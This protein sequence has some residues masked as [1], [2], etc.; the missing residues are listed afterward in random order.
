MGNLRRTWRRQ[1]RGL[2]R[3][4]QT[5]SWPN[6]I[7]LCRSSKK[8]PQEF[9]FAVARRGNEQANVRF[10][11]GALELYTAVRIIVHAS[12]CIVAYGAKHKAWQATVIHAII[13][14]NPCCWGIYLCI[15]S[16]R[17]P[18]GVVNSRR[19][20]QRSRRPSAFTRTHAHSKMSALSACF[21]N[22]NRVSV[23]VPH[24]RL[25]E[26]LSLGFEE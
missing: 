13:S 16:D 24:A 15:V 21:S 10:Q 8:G 26:V 6:S 2:Q 9:H 19:H 14:K 18:R 4:R 17:T 12:G 20:D 5:R 22:E 11:S 7:P 1:P 25:K 23:R 3:I